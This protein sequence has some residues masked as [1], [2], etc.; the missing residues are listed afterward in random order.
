MRRNKDLY[1]QFLPIDDIEEILKMP[2][3]I[4]FPLGTHL[5]L[6]EMLTDFISYCRNEASGDKS[7]KTSFSSKFWEEL[8]EKWQKIRE[9]TYHFNKDQ[10]RVLSYLVKKPKN[11]VN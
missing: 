11:G 9:P 8:P 1:E 10:L 4:Y 6:L 3:R 2:E 5:E 7:L